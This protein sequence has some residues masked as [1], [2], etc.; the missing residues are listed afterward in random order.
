MVKIELCLPKIHICH[1]ICNYKKL[2]TNINVE[3][4]DN[5]LHTI[6]CLSIANRSLVMTLIINTLKR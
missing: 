2:Y 4:F 6:E 5:I 1:N 3:S